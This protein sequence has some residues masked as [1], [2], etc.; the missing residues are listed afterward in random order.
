MQGDDARERVDPEHVLADGE[1]GLELQWR[2]AKCICMAGDDGTH[3]EVLGG[4]AAHITDILTKISC[5]SNN[6]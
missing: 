6:S 4:D 1:A 3:V 5:D 2:W